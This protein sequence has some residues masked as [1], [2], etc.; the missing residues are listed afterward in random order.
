LKKNKTETVLLYLYGQAGGKRRFYYAWNKR[1][2]LEKG[3]KC[4][5]NFFF[6]L[7]CVFLYKKNRTIHRPY[8]LYHL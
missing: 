6:Q 2:Q 5:S 1:N 7:C 8:T 3:K 4:F